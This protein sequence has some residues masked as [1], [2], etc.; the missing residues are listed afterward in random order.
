VW[1]GNKRADIAWKG[2]K[3]DF[4]GREQRSR[5]CMEG[6]KGRLFGEGAK[7]QVLHGRE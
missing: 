1:R 5:Y 7:E 4:E 2:V 6:S 3:E